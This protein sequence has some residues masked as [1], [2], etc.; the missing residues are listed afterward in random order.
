[1]YRVVTMALTVGLFLLGCTRR[2]DASAPEPGREEQA[3]SHSVEAETEPQASTTPGPAMP[4]APP[5][6][7]DHLAVTVAYDFLKAVAAGQYNA[8][9]ALSSQGVTAEALAQIHDTFQMDKAGF[10]QAWLG[11]E[12]VCVITS[13]VPTRDD[14]ATVVWGLALVR[15]GQDGWRIRDVDFLR[16]QEAIDRYLAQFHEAEPEAQPLAPSDE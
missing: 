5:A 15:S 11:A 7:S 3:P 8:A 14:S 16:G 6:E 12:Q 10:G 4:L 1:M 9:L 2:E 13:S